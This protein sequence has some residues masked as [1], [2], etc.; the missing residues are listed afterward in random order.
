MKKIF[1]VCMAA[2]ALVACNHN[3]PDDPA[4]K[5]ADFAKT[6]FF[7][8]LGTNT[9]PSEEYTKEN[10]RVEAQIKGDTAVDLLLYQ[11]N[12]S[13]RMPVSI[14]MVIPDVPCV[15]TADRITFAGENINPT[16]A[17]IPVTKYVITGLT[18]YITT[19][20]LVFRNNYGT[21]NDCSFAGAITYPNF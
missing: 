8:A 5:K 9:V 19:D 10:V 13:P 20:S 16:M 11:V 21:Y 4:D 7:E 15:R 3:N 18:G 6:T 2:L 12:F 14:D 1:Y 17:G